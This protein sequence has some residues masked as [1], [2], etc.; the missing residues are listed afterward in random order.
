VVGFLVAD[1]KWN[2]SRQSTTEVLA[3]HSR[4]SSRPSTTKVL[5]TVLLSGDHLLL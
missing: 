1:H 3:I 5:Y 2:I 4:C